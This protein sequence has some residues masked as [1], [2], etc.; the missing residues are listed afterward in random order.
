M[1]KEKSIKACFASPER[2][3][4]FLISFSGGKLGQKEGQKILSQL[5]EQKVVHF[6]E[7]NIFAESLIATCSLGDETRGKYI[8]NQVLIDNGIVIE[9]DA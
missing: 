6:A 2:R 8:I 1:K 4:T 7:I 9:E 5:R 3:S